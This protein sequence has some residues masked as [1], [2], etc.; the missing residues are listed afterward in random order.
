LF[1][2]LFIYLL[3]FIYL[4]LFFFLSLFLS[5][6]SCLTFNFWLLSGASVASCMV[7]YFWSTLPFYRKIIIIFVDTNQQTILVKYSRSI[8]KGDIDSIK[9]PLVLMGLVFNWIR[10]RRM[11]KWSL[12]KR[13][14]MY[15][16]TE[17][18]QVQLSLWMEWNKL[19]NTKWVE[20]PNDFLL[21][22]FISHDM[23]MSSF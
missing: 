23:R 5:F 3:I 7:V 22:L 13:R 6:W 12:S 16:W 4:F 17:P 18:L 10:Y 21:I 11:S 14:N 9:I 1:V 20:N 8:V 15:Q 19:W 2:C